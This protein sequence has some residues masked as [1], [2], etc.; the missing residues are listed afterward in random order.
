MELR[1][2]RDAHHWNN[3]VI[4]TFKLEESSDEDIEEASTLNW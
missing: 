1:L 4:K 2:I 3:T